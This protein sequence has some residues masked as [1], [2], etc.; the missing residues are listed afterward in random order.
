MLHFKEG[1]PITVDQLLRNQQIMQLLMGLNDSCTTMT[2]VILMMRPFPG[3]DDIIQIMNFNGGNGGR[4]RGSYGRGRGPFLKV[5]LVLGNHLKGL[6]MLDT[7]VQ[8]D[9]Q[10]HEFFSGSL[11]QSSVDFV[12]KHHVFHSSIASSS[13]SD[14]VNNSVV[15]NYVNIFVDHDVNTIVHSKSDGNKAMS[16]KTLCPSDCLLWHCRLDTARSLL[17]Q[18]N[19]PIQLWGECLLTTTYLVNRFPLPSLN[20]KSPFEKLFKIASTYTHLKFF[21]CLSF[22]STV[23]GMLYFMS[24]VFHSILH[25]YLLNLLYLPAIPDDF[26]IAILYPIDS[27]GSNTIND[28]SPDMFMSLVSNDLGSSSNSSADIVPHVARAGPNI[29]GALCEKRNRGP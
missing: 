22:A 29:Y 4:G 25:I 27:A 20:H 2:G 26:P 16:S 23:K 8:P 17:F 5:P 24:L 3:I 18:S 14:V 9:A 13:H 19:L 1:A 11:S 15:N 21:G 12:P 6:Y 10:L 28:S 7:V